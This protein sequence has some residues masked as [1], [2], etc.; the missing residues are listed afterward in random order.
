MIY[1]LY[2]RA[3][4]DHLLSNFIIEYSAPCVCLPTDCIRVIIYL[5][6]IFSFSA[7]YYLTSRFVCRLS[8]FLI[9][10]SGTLIRPIPNPFAL[11][12]SIILCFFKCAVRTQSNFGVFNQP[13]HT[14]HD[15]FRKSF[16]CIYSSNSVSIP[17]AA[18]TDYVIRILSVWYFGN[19]DRSNSALELS[20]SDH[21]C[22]QIRTPF[23][24]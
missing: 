22:D 1:L 3:N 14:A 6:C 5:K 11:C 7:N 4:R 20:S 18:D 12:N 17:V 16:V 13:Y 19:E 8:W 9:N 2:C 23:L 15:E 24:V 10:N 21:I